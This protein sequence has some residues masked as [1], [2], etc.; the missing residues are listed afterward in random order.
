MKMHWSAAAL[1]L[2]AVGCGNVTQDEVMAP[3]ELMPQESG[4]LTR[5]CVNDL[6]CRS[7]CTCE[8]GY[9]TPDAFGPPLGDPNY[10]DVA[11]VR[12]C[13][14]GADC[15][16]GC[17]CVGN[18]CIDNGFSPPANCL[19]A[20]A[21]T[22]ESDNTHLTASSYPGS[23]QLNHSFHRQGDVDWVIVF[24]PAAQLLTVETY[25]L[26]NSPTM[27]IDIYAYNYATRTLGALL[28]S[29]QSRICSQPISTCDK[30][31]AS[32]NA[33]ANNVYAIKVT[34]MR[35]V[36]AGSDWHPTPMYDLKMY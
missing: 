36:P 9:C 18:V 12:A 21:D 16:S 1:L 20:P 34:D 29:T 35:G 31:R 28:G 33:Q 8:A 4:L 27:R 7:G 26:R 25:N 32:A 24:V 6:N 11:P 5:S 23:P 13:N 30:Y 15:I 22:Y 3:P 17:N 19:L 10:C 2:A 14:T